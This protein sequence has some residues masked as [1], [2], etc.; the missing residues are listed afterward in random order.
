MEGV[1]MRKLW[2]VAAGGVVAGLLWASVASGQTPTINP[3]KVVFDSVNH[4]TVCPADA[5][6]L[7]YTVEV[8][9]VGV[10]PGTGSPISSS[11]LDKSKVATTGTTP[12]YRA[13]L[14]DCT[15]PVAPPPGTQVVIRLVA[16]GQYLSSAR[17]V[18]SNPFVRATAPGTPS[19]VAVS[20]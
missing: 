16:V 1:R 13:L 11:T 8:W 20:P 10:D 14:A 2:W 6:I 7:G 18:A 9:G 19:G 5:C 4:G 3:T 17:S 15:P 12:A